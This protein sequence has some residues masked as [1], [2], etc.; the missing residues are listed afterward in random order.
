MERPIRDSAMVGVVLILLAAVIGLAFGLFSLSKGTANEGVVESQGAVNNFMNI[1]Y[2]QFEDKIVTG[3]DVL[4]VF[5]TFSDKKLSIFV[6]TKKMESGKNVSLKNDR[7]VQFCNS[8]P[9]VNYGAILSNGKSQNVDD[10][11][12]VMKNSSVPTS[13]DSLFLLDGVINTDGAYC[14]DDNGMI[15]SDNDVGA[16][17]SS[18]AVEYIDENTK[19]NSNLIYDVTGD[20]VGICFTQI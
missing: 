11:V 5:K 14:L 8:I 13:E 6:H 3:R 7:Y 17:R 16:W 19:F 4:S 12:L 1:N 9:Y 2:S 20:I 15:I 18:S 10:L